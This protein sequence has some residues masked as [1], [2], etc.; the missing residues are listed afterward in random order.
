MQFARIAGLG[1]S[2]PDKVLDNLELEKM[3]D[4]SDEWITTRTGISQRRILGKDKGSSELGAKAAINALK[5]ADVAPDKVDLIIVTTVTPDTIFPSTACYI[6]KKIKAKNAACFDL[7][8]A[9]AG[10]V[11]GLACAEK[12][13]ISGMYKTI[14]VVST[15]VMSSI[16]D[17]T[18]RS[19]CVLFGDGAGAA[20]LTAS[21][22]ESFLATYLGSNGSYTD[23]LYVPAGGSKYSVT[24]EVLDNHDNCIRMRG[25]ELFRLAVRAMADAAQNALEL[26]KV[27]IDDIKLLIPHQAN[28]R[29]I[30]AIASRLKLPKE[31]VYVN[32]E[33]YGNMSAASSAIAFCEAWE[34]GLIKK[35]DIIVTAVFGAGLVWGSNVI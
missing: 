26:A 5:N 23:M 28:N 17:W 31:K 6:Q 4:T 32:I 22:K 7:S 19:T 9:C 11:Y 30:T 16:V 18:D 10:F 12:F 1:K 21:K 14:L 2:L 13:I 3:V 8:A 35:G 27:P 24:K 29:I 33:K 20:V 34:D 25:N 15:E